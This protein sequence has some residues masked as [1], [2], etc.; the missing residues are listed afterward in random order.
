MK[1]RHSVLM[2]KIFRSQVALAAILSIVLQGLVVLHSSAES[3]FKLISF[4]IPSQTLDLSLIAFSSQAD[5]NVIGVTQLLRNYRTQQVVGEMTWEQALNILTKNEDLDY[6]IVDDRSISIVL[7]N[8]FSKKNNYLDEIIVTAAGRVANLQETPVAVTVMRQEMLYQ[9]QVQDLR[10]LTKAVPGLE[11]ISTMPQAATLVQLRGVGTTNITEIADG[12]ISIHIDG[13]YSPRSQA[14]ASLLYD[15]D[16]VEVLRGPQGTLFGRNAS[17]GTINVHNKRPLLGELQSDFSLGAGNYNHREYRGAVNLPIDE[18]LAI[19][20]AAA[21]VKHDAYT[22]LLDNYVGM[23]LQYA[24]NEAQLSD[25]DQA[26]DYGQKGPETGDQSSMRIS[27]LWEPSSKISA[28]VSLE[29]YSDQGAGITELDPTL[30]N[31]GIRGVVIDSPTYLDLTNNSLRST[32][33]YDLDDLKL[34]YIFGKSNMKRQQI[35]DAD[36][37]WT[38]G[39]EQ[40]R[41]HSSSFRFESSEVQ[42]ASQNSEHM[43]WLAG[44][45]SSKERNS[46]VFAVDQQNAGGGRYPEGATSWINDFDG[47]A[48]SYAVQPDR[49]VNSL[50]VYT[51]AAHKINS[52]SRITL[53]LRYTKDSKSD[54]DGRAINCRVT[55]ALGPYV[56]DDSIHS[57]APSAHQIY[58]DTAT[59][60]A[61]LLGSYH[62]NGTSE[63]IDGEPCWIRQVNDL[64]VSWENTSGL[65]RYDFMPRDGVMYYASVSTGFKSGHIQDAGNSAE[66]ETV[67]N[68][69]LGLKSQYLDNSLRINAALFEANYHNLQFSNQD[70]L[71]INGDGIADTGGSTVVRNASEAKIRGLE[72][73]LDWLVTDLDYIKL[74]AAV[75]DAH[76]DKFAIP[77]TLFGNLFNPYVSEQGNA[78]TDAV[79]LS[80]NVPPRVPKWK[81]TASYKHDFILQSGLLSPRLMATVSD[82]YFLDIY[83]R[84][85]IPANVFDRLPNG[86]DNLGVQKAYGL[87]D[88]S[89]TYKH[90]AN[91][92]EIIGYLNNAFN[93]NVKIASGNVLTEQG[94][95]ATYMPP[96]TF[97]MMINFSLY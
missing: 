63:G 86:G 72:F 44:I 94:F 45:F 11:M 24:Q 43:D 64:K 59:K 82:H 97:G 92:W 93:K 41:T 87:L 65:L 58:A 42:L 6:R 91:N 51:Q 22:Q 69:E 3:R 84:D 68:Y 34:S 88:I 37:G 57:G 18:G 29:S 66:P 53:G 80:G 50:G 39:F 47:A 83:N 16:R 46:I 32:F 85:K 76:F 9:N 89:L 17:A 56:T 60:Q 81:V 33:T 31:Q 4:D 90:F 19:R 73:E 7:N 40:Q 70:R 21:T 26:I 48:V 74:S 67:T 96:R 95:V 15:I 28:F 38:G 12:P 25:F 75:T 36:N 49:R 23:G 35:I 20:L 13:I 27:G 1:N 2:P 77:D 5:V 8:N 10:D 14:A 54:Q 79:N 71:D 61:I 30:V 78:P 62:D 55:S 52:S